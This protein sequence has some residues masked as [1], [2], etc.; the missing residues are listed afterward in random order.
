MSSAAAAPVAAVGGAGGIAAPA[1][2]AADGADGKKVA[3]SKNWLPCESN[4][5]VMNA[6]LAKLG[7]PLTDHSVV[8]VLGTEDWAIEMVPSPALAVIMLFCIKDASE[9]HRAEEEARIVATPQ[10][11]PSSIYF[12]K[13]FVGN[14]CGTIALIHA[15]A[16]AMPG[17]A[18]TVTPAKG[19]FFEEFVARTAPMTADGRATALGEDESIDEAHEV[20][21]EQGQVR[22]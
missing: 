5:D 9:A 8:D 18:G 10:H 15:V 21:A 2:A 11:M 16:N 17:Y 6:Y 19:S 20:A 7:F 14:A 3:K 1:A 13:Q 12:M 4:P 22:I